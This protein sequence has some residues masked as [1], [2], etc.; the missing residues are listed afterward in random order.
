MRVEGEWIVGCF[1]WGG[2][3]RGKMVGMA[4]R[5]EGRVEGWMEW[6]LLWRLGMV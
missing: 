2:G 6:R 1:F 5:C 4:L 3:E